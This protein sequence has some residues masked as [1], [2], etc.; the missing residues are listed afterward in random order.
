[1]TRDRC[2]H[3][4]TENSTEQVR[5]QTVTGFTIYPDARFAGLVTTAKQAP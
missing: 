1:M 3:L 4:L 5:L 2:V